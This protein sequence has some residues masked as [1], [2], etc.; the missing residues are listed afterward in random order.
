MPLSLP[1]KQ[2][3]NCHNVG[4]SWASEG[5]I[6]GSGLAKDMERWLMFRCKEQ[7][8]Q[9][10]RTEDDLLR[11]GPPGNRIGS[12]GISHCPTT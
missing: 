8:K 12:P 5:P 1:Y 6:A 3:Q 2:R 11:S 4:I 9:L 10:G 7:Q